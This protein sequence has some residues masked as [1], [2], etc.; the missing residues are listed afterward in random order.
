[1]AWFQLL[2]GG[3][4]NVLPGPPALEPPERAWFDTPEPAA[5]EYTGPTRQPFPVLPLQVW[6]LR[7]ELDVVIE[8]R[9][10][11]WTMHE[12]ARVSDGSR[13]L[14][15]A[16]DADHEG[17]Q[18]ITAQVDGDVREWVPEIPVPRFAGPVDIEDRSA[19]DRVDLTIR[20]RSPEGEAMEARYAGRLPTKPSQPRNG[21]TMGHSRQTLAAL[22][23]LHL[24]RPGGDA[25]L[26]VDGV[27]SPIRRLFGLYPMKFVLAQ[28]QGGF[29]VADFFQA[30][31]E[32]GFD[33]SRPADPA[34]TPDWP[35]RARE[36]WSVAD[37]WARRSTPGALTSLAYHF[38]DGEL[39]RARVDQ[40]GM[41]APAT[42]VV[43][44]PSLPD[45]NR[46]F[47]GVAE[48]RFTVDIAGQLGHGTGVAR[49]RW[50]DADTVTVELRPTAPA[51]FASRPIDVVIHHTA[52]GARV[53]ATMV[54]G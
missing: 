13:S 18:F 9:H 43:F 37:G 25:E 32:G 26:L 46:P 48:S 54:G 50:T 16:K 12:Y 20:Y 27:R 5:V 8:T 47:A 3:L 31:A 42:E 33:L 17:R 2:A 10:P 51:W 41:D 39:D 30:A 22:L 49:A 19:G 44:R 45:L 35:T 36:A 40:A 6:G 1:M 29:A 21:N 38:R 7:Y 34:A 23:D 53:R 15:I 14:W 24:F 4:A 52:E 11:R 28:T